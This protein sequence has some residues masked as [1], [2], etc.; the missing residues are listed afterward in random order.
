MGAVF[1]IFAAYYYWSPKMYGFMYNE[2]LAKIHFW[3][4]FIGVNITFM[5]MHFLGLAGMP[6]R[7]S[8]YPDNYLPWNIVASFG[9]MISMIAVFLFI[10]IVYKQFTDKIPA[11]NTNTFGYFYHYKVKDNYM[12][13]SHNLEFLL[14][15]P[16]RFHTF[17]QLPTL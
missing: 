15:N 8:D 2:L 12:N 13:A 1:A 6:R 11:T 17:N 4:F 10:I 3:L 14:E 5:P 7:I 16:P 9:S